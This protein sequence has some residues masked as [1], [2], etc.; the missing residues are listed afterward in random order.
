MIRGVRESTVRRYMRLFETEPALRAANEALVQFARSHPIVNH[1]GTGYAASSDLMSL[2]ASK[3]LY[4][5]RVDP[6]RRVH[7]VGIYQTVLDQ[8]GIPYDAP[9]PLLQRQAGAAIEGV[10]RQ[11]VTPIRWLAVDTHGF[12]FVANAVAKLLGFDLC[13]RQR[14]MRE[15][16][17]HVPHGWPQMPVLEPVLRRDVDLE[18]IHAEYDSMLRIVASIDEGYTSATYMLERLG[19]AARG[20][21][22]YN[23]LLQLGQLWTSVHVCDYAAQPPF[24][25]AVNRLL[26]RGESV[27]QLERAIH[28]GPIR[29]DRGRRR[30][31]LVLIS[32]AL[33]LLTNAVIAYNTW[34]LN[35]VL[36]KRRAKGR[37]LPSDHILAHT[38]PIASSH[39]NF[40]GVYRFPIEQYLDRL[41]PAAANLPK[42]VRA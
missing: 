32:G 20:S 12:T 15:Q 31:E 26:V 2:D 33:T 16:W 9:L 18:L 39:I 10:L 23:A 13:P 41:L 17:L 1:W 36:E 8:W 19:T 28:Y 27:H 24:R 35:E 3:H 6:R 4:N 42:I 14:D 5:A 11:H 29:A 38:A 21:H 25:R 37:A 30:D 40:R 34:K 7:G 22:L